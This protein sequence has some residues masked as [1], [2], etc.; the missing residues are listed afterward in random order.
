MLDK[1]IPYYNVIMK[2][3]SGLPLPRFDLPAGFS[4]AWYAAGMER[5]W[6][7][8]EAS[9]GEF[10]TAGE[11]LDYFLQEYLPYVDELK[12][13]LLFVINADGEPVGTITGWWNYSGERRDA[14]IHWFAVREADQGQGLG[15]ALVAACL[16]NL[17]ALDGDQAIYLHTQ[18]W[19]GKAVALYRKLGFQIEEHETF[20]HYRNDYAQALPLLLA[21]LNRN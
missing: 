12:Q 5:D 15:K 11:G 8:I 2:R 9:V 18:T 14:A 16:R 13:R 19:S 20:A 6:A 3:P 21:A 1:T 10:E 4:F 7:V 17:L